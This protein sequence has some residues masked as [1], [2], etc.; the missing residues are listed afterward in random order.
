MST[1]TPGPWR[2][3]ADLD[4]SAAFEGKIQN[5]FFI[6]A[7]DHPDWDPSPGEV[8]MLTVK[9]GKFPEILIGS[10]THE[11]NA[12]LIAA[13]PLLLELLK[14]AEALL[15]LRSVAGVDSENLVL[16]VEIQDKVKR[17]IQHIEEA[18]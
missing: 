5:S 10:I 3:K 7:P 16:S 2:Y 8:T 14:K 13:A 11:A 9:N 6:Y 17:L 1:H 12:R 18:G 15:D 4:E